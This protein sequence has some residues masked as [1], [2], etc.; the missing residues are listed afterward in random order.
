[1]PSE[2]EIPVLL[3]KFNGVDIATDS[4]F[5]GPDYLQSAQNFIPD[6]TFLLSKR[7]G[8]TTFRDLATDIGGT[9][10]GFQGALYI[11]SSDLLY[12][13]A[14]PNAT[15]KE[16]LY[17]SS[18]G[19]AFAAV[20]TGA[21]TTLA[22]YAYGM[23]SI[24]GNLY[25]SNGINAIKQVPFSGTAFDLVVLPIFTDTTAAPAPTAK[26]TDSPSNIQAGLYSFRWAV[27][28]N[29]LKTWIKIGSR[30][31]LPNTTPNTVTITG[32]ELSALSFTSPAAGDYTLG[33]NETFHLFVAPVNLPIEFA[34]DQTPEGVPNATARTVTRITADNDAVPQIGITRTGRYLVPHRGRLWI[35][36][37]QTSETSKSFVYAT[38]IIIPGLEQNIYNRGIFF[39][40]NA[41]FSVSPNDGEPIRGIA[42]AN[43]SLSYDTP[44]SPLLIF[45]D[46][47]TWAWFGDILD[48]D[49][50]QLVQLSNHV[51]CVAGATICS[52]PVGVIFCGHDSIYLISPNS[53]EPIDIGKSISPAI[54]SASATGRFFA[55]A[56]YHKNFY[57]LAISPT[58]T[59]TN[60]QQWWLDLSNGLQNSW[61]GPHVLPTYANMTTHV[62]NT[63]EYDRGF[64][65]PQGAT[66]KVHLIHQLSTYTDVS[67]TTPVSITSTLITKAIDGGQPFQRK[68]YTRLRV[69]GRIDSGKT[70]VGITVTTDGG[71]FTPSSPLM[72]ENTTGSSWDPP[73]GA[74][75]DSSTW[76]ASG[77]F[78]ESECILPTNRP[79]GQYVQVNLNHIDPV[80]L[81]MR[82]FELRYIPKDREVA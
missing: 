59:T 79:T 62:T 4:A 50:A 25:V 29:V 30:T 14:V 54:R 40:A 35:S 45:K 21:F 17:V 11:G 61:W 82:D 39:P 20:P 41:A 60:T 43:A 71:I 1:M 26:A 70:S 49:S 72:W 65:V 18:A 28:D 37:D 73:G 27:Y 22:N 47:S 81:D 55:C 6:P 48:D 12:V 2:K 9:W 58:G 5:I 78:Q 52:T 51:G 34:H 44:S 3:R 38:S 13:V 10:A 19:G 77:N 23:A 36:G 16:T 33:A 42:V 7:P 15:S 57:K 80:R 64:G 31:A 63:S 75:W 66:G 76:A 67:P 32:A 56:V 53:L 69:N 24:G 8:S 68:I 46:S 74:I